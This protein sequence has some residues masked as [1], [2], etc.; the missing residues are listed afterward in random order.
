MHL[1]GYHDGG[2]YALTERLVTVS[3]LTCPATCSLECPSAAPLDRRCHRC[4]RPPGIV[5]SLA[6]RCRAVTTAWNAACLDDVN[7]DSHHEHGPDDPEDPDG[8]A[9]GTVIRTRPHHG[10][11]VGRL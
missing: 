5:T 6:V 8:M 4:H 1:Q 3:L 7:L 10:T 2:E 11:W 9:P